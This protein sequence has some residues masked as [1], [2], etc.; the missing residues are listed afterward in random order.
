[1]E[2]QY[3]RTILNEV[4]NGIAMLESYLAFPCKVKYIG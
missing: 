3:L 2:K 1:M 4:Q